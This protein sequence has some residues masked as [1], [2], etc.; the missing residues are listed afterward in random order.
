MM[1][2]EKSENDLRIIKGVRERRGKEKGE[3]RH[4]GGHV[5][6]KEEKSGWG[7]GMSLE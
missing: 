1:K 5:Q 7:D 3:V 2:K 4:R 6:R